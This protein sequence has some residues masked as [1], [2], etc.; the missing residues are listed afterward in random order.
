MENDFV[1]Y[2][3]KGYKYF[4]YDSEGGMHYFKHKEDRDKAARECIQS[5]HDSDGWYPEVESIS[6]GEVTGVATAV[7][8][9]D[10]PEKI[11]FNSD[12]DYQDALEELMF[13]GNDFAYRCRYEIKPLEE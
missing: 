11:E 4:L 1:T 9:V 6:V 13:D 3:R 7:D 10:R 8:V 2:P 5:Y 12:Q